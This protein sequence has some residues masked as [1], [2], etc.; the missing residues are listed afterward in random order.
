MKSFESKLIWKFIYRVWP[1]ILRFLEMIRIHNVRQPFLVGRLRADKKEE[2]LKRFLVEL[3]FQPAILAWK[4]PC[5]T[6]S[7]RKMVDS[8][9]Q[10][11][12]RHFPEGDVHVHIE[13]AP[14]TNP[15]GHIR[16]Y[17]LENPKAQVRSMLGSF[18]QD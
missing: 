11:H 3:G 18:I 17:D 8:V 15:W 9:R 12:I 14:E 1:P 10:L 16:E 6:L 2:D 13:F 7:M 4:D 5:E